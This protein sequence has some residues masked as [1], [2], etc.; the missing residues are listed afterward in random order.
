[1]SER[2]WRIAGRHVTVDSH[3]VDA[4]TIWTRYCRPWLA[5]NHAR[6]LAS[7]G[8][9]VSLIVAP[10]RGRA[11][12]VVGRGD[13][14]RT[15]AGTLN[16]SGGPPARLPAHFLR[17][18]CSTAVRAAVDGRDRQCRGAARWML[19]GAAWVRRRSWRRSAGLAQMCDEQVAEP[20][21]DTLTSIKDFHVRSG[22]WGSRLISA[23]VQVIVVPV[24][25]SLAAVS[26]GGS[27]S[28]LSWWA[29]NVIAVSWRT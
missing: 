2:G 12:P 28:A 23:F 27:W 18:S 16:R 15:A 22:V 13:I 29:A 3:A 10:R 1:L 26:S 7:F 8:A 5:W 24:L 17:L 9:T 19:R 20:P 6:T 11:R 21:S 4:G 14:R 25:R